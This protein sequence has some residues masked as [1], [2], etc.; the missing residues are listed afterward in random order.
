MNPERA[1]ILPRE[2]SKTRVGGT[3]ENPVAVIER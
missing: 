1:R 2:P 3:P